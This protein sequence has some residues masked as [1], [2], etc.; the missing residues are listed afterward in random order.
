MNVFQKCLRR[1]MGNQ[2]YHS[3]YKKCAE[4]FSQSNLSQL[5]TNDG[6]LHDALY[7]C[8]KKDDFEGLEEKKRDISETLRT[9]VRI[10][11]YFGLVI[12]AYLFGNII[13]LAL[14]L[15]Y[16]VTCVSILLMGICFIYK[17]IEYISNSKLL[18]AKTLFATHYHELTELEGKIENVNNYCIAVKEKGDDIIFLRKIVKGGADKSYGIQVA[19]LAGVPQS[20]TDRAKEIVEEL[21][22]ADVTGKIKEIEVQGQ[23]AS[24]PKTKHFDEVDLA[25]MSLFDTVQDNDIVEEIKNLDMTNLTPMEAMNILYNLQNKIKNRW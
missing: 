9:A 23:E 15:D 6:H 20:V 1:Q 7:E 22:Q 2:V 3:F 18:G 25:Q 10:T 21:V 24:K 4:K 16:Y 17:L 5:N 14:D 8:I 12:L 11:K 19:R 13:L